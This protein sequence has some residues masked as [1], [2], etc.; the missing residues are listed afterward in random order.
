MEKLFPLPDEYYPFKNVGG[1]TNKFFFRTLYDVEY[2]VVFK[3]SPYIFG[4]EKPYAQLLFEFSILAKFAG[5]QSYVRDDLI[6]ATVAAIF[7]T[8]YNEHD[9]N[10][11]FYICDS[12][13]GKQHVRKRKF[14]M[15][16]NQ[17]N[18]GAF[19]KFDSYLNDADGVVYPVAIIMASDNLYRED[20]SR[21]FTNLIT[22]YNDEK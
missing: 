11:C 16:F 12:S 14:D 6:A 13:D 18:H 10:V 20:I 21:A 8:F 7:L 3:P 4:E 17:Y 2:T 15:W 22:G 1:Q 5:L 9:Q 19:S